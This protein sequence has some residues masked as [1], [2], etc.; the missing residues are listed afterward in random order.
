MSLAGELFPLDPHIRYVAENRRGTIVEMAQSPERPT[1]NPHESDRIE[2]LIVNPVLLELVR[3]RGELDLDGMRWVLIRYGT[4]YELVIPTDEGH[5]SVGIDLEADVTD[6][7]D[8]VL[9]RLS[10]RPGAGSGRP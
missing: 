4:L 9:K 10:P 1:L 2:E 8:R 5:V 6:V 7:V 3:R